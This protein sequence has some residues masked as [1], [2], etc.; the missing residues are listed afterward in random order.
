MRWTRFFWRYVTHRKDLAI[1]LL[2]CAAIVAAAELMIPWLLH[3]AIDTALGVD[4]DASLNTWG[5]CMLGVVVVLYGSHAGLL[6]IEARMLY[7]ASYQLRRRLYAHFHSQSLAFFQRHKT[8][9][10]LHRVNSD[11]GVFEDNAVELFSSLPFEVLTVV[12]VLTIMGLTEPRL[13]LLIIVFLLL[14]SV[15]TGYLGRPLPT[16]RKSIQG[17]GARLS[18]RLQEGLS[19]VRTV[20]AFKNEDYEL[21]RLDE[22]NREILRTEVTAGRLEG[23][24]QPIFDLMEQLG[25]ILVVW[26]GGHLIMADQITAGALV[27]FI[28]YME[29]LAGPIS[30]AGKFYTHFQTCRA[31]AE[32]LQQLLD[33]HDVLP[34]RGNYTLAGNHAEVQVEAVSFQYPGSTREV[35][36]NVSFTLRYGETVAIVG[37]NGAGKSTLIDL[38]LRFYDPTN[39]RITV[40]GVDLR[41]WDLNAWRHMVGVMSQDVFLFQASIAEN[42]AYGRL[43]ATRA[44]V[45]R[46]VQASGMEAFIQR[47]PQGLETMVGERGA[48]LSGGERQRLA[49]ARLFLR[50]PHLLILDE[51]TAHLD[52]EALHQIGTALQPLMEGRTTILV[53]HRPETIQLADRILLLDQ[54]TLLAEGTH[55]SLAHTHALYRTLLAEMDSSGG[56][57]RPRRKDPVC[58]EGRS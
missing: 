44:D 5:L 54:G 56:R 22:A 47:L 12:G 14:A 57:A 37:R 15:L 51:P 49:L 53:A 3:Q 31:L 1:A 27:A 41:D 39:G 38:C 18:G 43:N 26:Y 45:E 20:Q 17:I 4:T 6:R 11:T 30:R 21:S 36:R 16:L 13:M 23:L 7:E 33:D 32:R 46:A 2:S 9:E 29:I 10:L 48:K 40:G 25:V 35:L 52:G 19:G 24:L 55:D 58:T 34:Q 50:D 8:G 42:I 28:A